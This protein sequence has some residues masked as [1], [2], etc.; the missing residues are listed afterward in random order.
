ME[1]HISQTQAGI[2]FQQVSSENYVKGSME[3]AY[4]FIDQSQFP[5]VIVSFTGLKATKKNFQSYLKD[6]SELYARKEPIVIVFDATLTPFIKLRLQ[7]RQTKWMA[8]NYSMVKK[9]C[10]GTAYVIPNNIIRT[11]LK[12]IFALRRQSAPYKI[13]AT[14]EAGIAWAKSKTVSVGSIR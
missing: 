6:L 4:A 5:L 1:M 3:K 14:M 9:F 8:E 10:I 7:K 12:T 2:S 13:F 11:V